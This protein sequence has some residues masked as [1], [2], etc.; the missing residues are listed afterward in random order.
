MRNVMILWPFEGAWAV[1]IAALLVLPGCQREND[2]VLGA[3]A[4]NNTSAGRSPEESYRE[5]IGTFRREVAN[6]RVDVSSR[7]GAFSRLEYQREVHDQL[8]P[9][10]DPT[11]IYRARITVITRSSFH[12]RPPLGDDASGDEAGGED[13]RDSD[14]S[15]DIE[16]PGRD[17]LDLLNA[18]L[19]NP[20]RS[21]PPRKG[22]VQTVGTDTENED[23]QTYELAYENDRW[24]LKTVP[25]AD[26]EQFIRHVF[27]YA[28]KRQ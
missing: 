15:L 7:A 14:L 11:D 27:E 10:A 12:Y 24:V 19:Q 28:L 8:I 25:E 26:D 1:A 23:K 2:P 9:P 3:T 21:S 13:S 18:E 20:A 16:D 5:I 22:P 17:P 4:A 6:Q